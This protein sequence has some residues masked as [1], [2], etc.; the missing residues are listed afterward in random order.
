VGSDIH[1]LTLRYGGLKDILSDHRVEKPDHLT[2]Y[3]LQF[4]AL[5]SMCSSV[6]DNVDVKDDASPQ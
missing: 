5:L 3:S 2:W 4:N 1:D 6:S